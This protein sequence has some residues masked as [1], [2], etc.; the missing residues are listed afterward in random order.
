MKMVIDVK[1]IVSKIHSDWDGKGKFSRHL[2]KNGKLINEKVLKIIGKPTHDYK[3]LID[4]RSADRESVL[5]I[6][7]KTDSNVMLHEED[8]EIAAIMNEYGQKFID[9]GLMYTL[10]M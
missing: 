6:L 3:M 1:P 10:V 7:R 4:F 2:A 8:F 5:T 9:A